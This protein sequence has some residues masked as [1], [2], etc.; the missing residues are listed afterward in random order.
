MV[1]HDKDQDVT[2]SL[3]RELVRLQQAN[4]RSR[5]VLEAQYGKVYD[6]DEF[7]RAF[8]LHGFAAPFVMVTEIKTNRRGSL[9]FQHMPRFYY[10]FVPD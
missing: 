8:V 3:R 2:G 7:K 5:A 4:I 10:S 1:D 6:T 9:E